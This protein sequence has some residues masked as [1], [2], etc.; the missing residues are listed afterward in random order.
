M[1]ATPG[2]FDALTGT[3][4]LH[5]AWVT[6]WISLASQGIA[7]VI[8][9]VLGPL[10]SS[11]IIPLRFVTWFYVWFFRGSPELMQ[12]IAWY[13]I[14]PMLGVNL[15]LIQVGLVGLSVNEG[16]R[17]C[18]IVRAALSSVERGQVDAARVLGM[19]SFKVFRLVTLPQAAK[20]IIA[21]LGNQMNYMFK[22]SSLISVIGIVE[23]LR[24]TELLTQTAKQPLSIYLATSVIYLLITT[25]WGIAQWFV[26]RTAGRS[27]ASAPAQGGRRFG[28]NEWFPLAGREL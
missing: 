21:P 13:S 8:G 23:L 20:L 11:R 2:F 3:S 10:R 27:R 18:E 28:L 24:N 14:L 4:V 15:T 12:I 17:M 7:L 9:L 6:I 22:T 25:V 19:N 5:A 26:E 1:T 16:A